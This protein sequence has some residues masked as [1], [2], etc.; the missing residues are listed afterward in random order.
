MTTKTTR[1]IVRLEHMVRYC[2]G[3]YTRAWMDRHLRAAE[4]WFNSAEAAN[5]RLN[6]LLIR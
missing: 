4:H 2:M 5:R 6:S 3:R 1:N